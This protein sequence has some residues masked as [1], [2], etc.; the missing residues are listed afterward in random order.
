M[1]LD[2]NEAYSKSLEYFDNDELA[3]NVFITKYALTDRD[4]KIHEATP[5]EMHRRMASEFARIESK[6]EN[7]M[8]E[9]EIYGC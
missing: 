3:A 8:G 1:T 2:F 4:G 7:P 6:Y 9:D 5:D